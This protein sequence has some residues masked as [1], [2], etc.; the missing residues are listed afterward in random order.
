M[1]LLF[2]KEYNNP[3]KLQQPIKSYLKKI[4]TKQFPHHIF[5]PFNN[6]INKKNQE[7]EQRASQI[8]FNYLKITKLNKNNLANKLASLS[9]QSTDINKKRHEIIQDFMLANDTTTIA[10]ELPVYLTHDDIL[11]FTSRKFYLNLSNYKT[12]ITGHIDILQIRNNLIHILD[13]KPNSSKTNPVEQLLIY[14]LAL[15]SRTK[16]PLSRFKCAW[17]DESNYYEFFPLHLVYKNQIT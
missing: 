8:K 15:S 4:P 12:P 3:S 14:S 1:E 11:Y 17:F 2:N 10:T 7:K 9:L 5:K 16:L 13:Y 6:L